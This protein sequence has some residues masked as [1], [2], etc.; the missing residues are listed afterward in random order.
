MNTHTMPSE[1]MHFMDRLR[2]VL[3]ALGVAIHAAMAFDTGRQWVVSDPSGHPA[4]GIVVNVI[5]L[6]RMPLFFLVSGY[7]TCLLYDKYSVSQFLRGRA[8]RIV[9]PFLATLL[10]ANTMLI[11]VFEA[12]HLRTVTI[13]HWIGPLWFLAYLYAYLSVFSL[14]MRWGD[15]LRIPAA[16]TERLCTTNWRWPAIMA[17]FVVAFVAV[18]SIVKLCGLWDT[19]WIGFVDAFD[20]LEYSVYFAAGL[21]M[22]RSRAFF[23]AMTRA[24]VAIA[25]SAL[26]TLLVFVGQHHF[27]WPN[28]GDGLLHYLLQKAAVVL[29]AAVVMTT[30]RKTCDADSPGARFFADASYTIY[31]LHGPFLVGFATL[32]L[33]VAL[34]ALIKFVMLVA[35]TLAC[36]LALHAW[37]IARAPLLT[38]LFNGKIVRA[39]GAEQ[40]LRSF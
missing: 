32:L 36:T 33:P 7:F 19:V 2:G 5:H 26:A 24:N 28:L 16:M 37:I 25:I 4:F 30:F 23:D 20:F 6:Y 39:R 31:L 22:Y 3:M 12:S 1:R 38:L 40:E 9:V 18:R 8:L 10:T 21:L 17:A 35:F 27:G 11:L 29:G 34:P 13:A 15:S 14:S